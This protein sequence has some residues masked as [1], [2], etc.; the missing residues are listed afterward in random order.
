MGL[1]HASFPATEL[2]A[3]VSESV[4]PCVHAF[5]YLFAEGETFH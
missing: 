2:K 4:D 1:T 3:Q 5:E